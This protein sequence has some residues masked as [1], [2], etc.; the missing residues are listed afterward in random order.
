MQIFKKSTVLKLEWFKKKHRLSKKKYVILDTS[1]FIPLS[2]SRVPLVGGTTCYPTSN[3]TTLLFS[4]GQRGRRRGVVQRGRAWR[5]AYWGATTWSFIASP[6]ILWLGGRGWGNTPRHRGR[7]GA[8]PRW[9]G[10]VEAKRMGYWPRA[11]G[12]TTPLVVY[13]LVVYFHAP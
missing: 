4:V 1:L 12:C 3:P 2:W 8:W 10:R 11:W 6:A 5:T 7:I 13:C 9:L